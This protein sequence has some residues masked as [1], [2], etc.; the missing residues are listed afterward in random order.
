M[1]MVSDLAAMRREYTASG[2]TE[3]D[4]DPDPIRQF[5]RWFEGARES[6]V[7]EPNAM[8]LATVD[9][10][11]QPSVRIVLLKGVDE[12]GLT[13]FTNFESRKGQALAAEPRAAATFWWGPLE[14]QVRFEGEVAKAEDEIAD[15][16]FASR[17]EGARIGA[18][19]SRQSA[20]VASRTVLEEEAGRQAARFADGEMPRPPYW[21]GYR[22]TPRRIEFWQGRQDRLHDRLLFTADGSGGWRIERLSP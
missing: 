22:L 6:G 19:A 11:G 3:A 16:Y 12:R 20:V 5:E 18:W 7:H 17:P 8:A 10:D 1:S 15:A 13:F 14:R 2:L 4:V 21:G 9:P